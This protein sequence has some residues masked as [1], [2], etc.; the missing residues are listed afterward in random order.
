MTIS[1]LMTGQFITKGDFMK[2]EIQTR[3]INEWENV[4]HCNGELEYF[5]TYEAAHQSLN[6][7]IDEMEDEQLSGN[8]EDK[9]DIEDFRI[10]EAICF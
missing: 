1:F 7:F 9:Y 5:D 6:N 3:F 10:V 8:I 4:W 2:Y